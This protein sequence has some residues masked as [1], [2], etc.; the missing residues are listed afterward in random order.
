[1]LPVLIYE[2]NEADR[3]CILRFLTDCSDRQGQQFR[4]LS[5]ADRLDEAA[6]Y[7]RAESGVL[8]LIIGVTSAEILGATALER[9][10]VESNRDNYALYWLH[11][12]GDLP[13]IAGACL[14]PAGF[15]I[16]PPKE[17]QFRRVIHRVYEDYEALSEAPADMFLAL[18]SGGGVYRLPVGQILYIEA[19]DKKLNI[20]TKRQCLTVYDKLAGVERRLGARFVRCHRSYLVNYTRIERADF[21]KMELLLTNGTR[22]PLSRSGKEA[23]KQRMKQE[24]DEV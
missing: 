12:P 3:Q 2:P 1:M 17:E 9:L 21:V 4:L 23:L 14:H 10:C 8:L 16:P 22:L 11:D 13:E 5:C 19:L 24:T 6:R 7:L 15:I 18:Q 20:W